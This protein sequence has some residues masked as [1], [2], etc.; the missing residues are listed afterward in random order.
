MNK[1]IN[2]QTATLFGVLANFSFLLFI[3][4]GLCYYLIASTTAS[5]A[6]ETAGEFGVMPFEIIGFVFL[7]AYTIAYDMLLANSK[8][9]KAMISVYCVAELIIMLCDFGVIFQSIYNR[10]SVVLIVLHMLFSAVMLYSYSRLD[11]CFDGL[12]IASLIAVMIALILPIALWCIFKFQIYYSVLSNAIALI[13]LNGYMYNKLA[14]GDMVVEALSFDEK[15]GFVLN[16]KQ[17]KDSL[18]GRDDNDEQ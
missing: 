5:T 14:S 11:Y 16:E 10:Q 1:H 9:F 3:F 18:E 15:K 7:F 8:P 2:I 6:L 12:R 17:R 13:W 4:L